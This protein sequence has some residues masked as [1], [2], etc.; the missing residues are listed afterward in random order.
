MISKS[1]FRPEWPAHLIC[2]KNYDKAI[3]D[4]TQIWEVHHRL[5]THTSDGERRIVE[6]SKA[7]L[8]AFDMYYDRPPEELIFLT[9]RDHFHLHSPCYKRTKEQFEKAA[10][11]RKGQ[12]RNEQTKKIIDSKRV[13]CVETGDVYCSVT[14]AQ[15]S[16][17]IK[18]SISAVCRGE[19]KRAGGFHWKYIQ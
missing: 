5:E 17:G 15:L 14:A 9:K 19:R 18:T 10:V 11:K 4:K 6:L 16:T 12:K 1:S 2:S 7:E 3:A 8:E 13:L